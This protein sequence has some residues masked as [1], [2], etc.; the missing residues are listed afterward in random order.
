MTTITIEKLDEVHIRILSDP[1]TEQELVDYFKF[2]MDGYQFSP[3]FKAKLWDGFVR[4]YDVNRKTLYLGLYNYV[5]TF[6]KKNDIEVVIKGDFI[7]VNEITEDEVFEYITSLNLQG[8][9]NKPIVIRD[10][11]VSAV[12]EA[13]ANERN[14]LLSPTGSGKSLII[15][16]LS[17]WWRETD[18]KVLILVPTTSLVE[19]L[20]SDFE[21]YSGS[22]DWSVE[23]NCQK[24]YSGFSKTF[25]KNI[26]FSTWQSVHRQPK[27]WFDQFDVIIGDEAHTFKS[28][29]LVAIMAKM[30]DVQYRIGTTGTIDNKKVHKLVLEGIFGPV[31]KVTST[32]KLMDQGTLAELKITCLILKYDDEIRKANKGLEYKDEIEFIVS[33]KA[34]NRF[35][36]NLAIQTKGNTLLLFQYVERHGKILYE[37]L[38]TKLEGSERNV[39][40]IHGKVDVDV[41]EQIRKLMETE[42]DAIVVASFG[43]MSTGTNVPSIE[44]I[45]FASPSKSK[46][47]NLQS[48]GRGLRMKEGKTTCKL[49]DVVDNLSWKSSKNHTLNHFGER[50]KIY[51]EEEFEFKLVELKI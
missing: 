14:V 36:S 25:S 43:T 44:N 26:L 46:I 51:A 39:Y 24:L 5:L 22:N 2:R 45:I 31:Y 3:K 40:F 20:Y 18:K 48:I 13:L 23:V 10:Y 47:R 29:A 16:S 27:S 28:N 17:R 12:R 19:Q 21:D 4:L 33:N 35:V 7:G 30:T 34:R 9:G 6:A 15:Y 38:K 41:R 1:S 37:L 49:Y 32:K 8:A 50:L 11:Q 42:E